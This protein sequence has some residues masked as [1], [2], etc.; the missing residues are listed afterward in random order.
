MDPIIRKNERWR[1]EEE[2]REACLYLLVLVGGF[3]AFGLVGWGWRS[4]RIVLYA[5]YGTCT[6]IRY[7]VNTIV[8]TTTDSSRTTD[9]TI[10][11]ILYFFACLDAVVVVVVVVVVREKA[12]SW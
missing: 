6:I 9:S 12:E 11:T 1:K 2:R 3:V 4:V 7:Q 10:G 5:W 8:N